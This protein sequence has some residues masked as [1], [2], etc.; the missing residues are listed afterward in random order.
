MKSRLIREMP[1]SATGS[2]GSS[3]GAFVLLGNTVNRCQFVASQ[4]A[5]R[6]GGLKKWRSQV[7]Q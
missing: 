6:I 4:M 3:Y 1:V 2:S 7:I 5:W